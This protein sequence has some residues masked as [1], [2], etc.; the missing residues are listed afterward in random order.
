MSQLEKNGIISYMRAKIKKSIIDILDNQSESMKQ[1]LEFDYMTPLHRLNKTKEIIL[2]G[3]L[4]KQFM[5]Y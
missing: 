2:A 4:I 3:H 5:E 1:K